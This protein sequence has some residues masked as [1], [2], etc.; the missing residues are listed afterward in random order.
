MQNI[1]DVVTIGGSWNEMEHL[2]VVVSELQRISR[3]FA[4][5][6]SMGLTASMNPFGQFIQQLASTG[7]IH[8]PTREAFITLL[9]T[10]GWQVTNQQQD[11]I[12]Q[13]IR[14][15]QRG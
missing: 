9:A 3:P 10:Y 7:G 5:L 11:G 14:A 15:Q 1:A 8:F 13:L 2:E 4:T 12:V 6:R